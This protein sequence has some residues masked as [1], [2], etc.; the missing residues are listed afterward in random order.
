MTS[1]PTSEP[2][3]DRSHPVREFAR[4][5]TAR[6]DQVAASPVWSMSPGEQ[7]DTLRDLA[8]ARA[9]LDA[10]SLKVLAEADRSGAT[11]VD[12]ACSAADWLA[13][14]T[15]QVRRSTRAD[16]HLAKAPGGPRGARGCDGEGG[17]ERAAGA[18][19]HPGAG[20]AARLG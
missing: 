9:Q 17:G 7:R 20:P 13:V 1:E 15:Q 14:E 16:L 10:L 18:G 2:I 11:D 6:L 12:A 3:L 5:L 8:R 4:Q 19:D